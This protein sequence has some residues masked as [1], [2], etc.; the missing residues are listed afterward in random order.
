MFYIIMNSRNSHIVE[1]LM[2]EAAHYKGA[3]KL[4][5]RPTE[6]ADHASIIHI[7]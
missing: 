2:V 7:K 3:T 1:F 4:A 6:N 5:P